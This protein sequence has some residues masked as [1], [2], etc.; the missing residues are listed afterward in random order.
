MKKANIKKRLALFLVAFGL[1]LGF[2]LWYGIRISKER[3]KERELLLIAAYGSYVDFAVTDSRISPSV[4]EELQLNR[5]N[6]DEVQYT[7]IVFVRSPEEA[8]G[9]GEY[10]LVAWPRDN[11]YGNRGPNPVRGTQWM[12][13]GFNEVFL[14]K[15][16]DIDFRNYGLPEN[17]ITIADT[18]DRWEI[19]DMLIRKY[20]YGTY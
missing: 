10:V 12:L 11:V 3:E 14:E 2:F 16:P 13:D 1:L 17:E 20:I 15:V 18:V 19:V 5:K 4:L 8:V 7:E 6:P 9:F